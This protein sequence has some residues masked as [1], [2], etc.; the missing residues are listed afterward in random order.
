MNWSSMFFNFFRRIHW[1]SNNWSIKKLSNVLI[2]SISFLLKRTKTMSLPIAVKIDISPLCNLRCT[3]CVHCH[4]D[5]NKILEKQRFNYKQQMSVKQYERIITEIK[6]YVSV[7]SLY[8]FGD[9]LLHPDL[10]KLCEVTANAGLNSHV[11]TN[12]SLNMSDEKIANLIKSGLTFL[13]VCVDGISQEKYSKTRV[14]G[15]VELVLL[16]LERFCKIRKQLKQTYPKIEVQYIKYQHNIDEF[17]EAKKLLYK[18]GVDR[19]VEFWGFLHNY[20]DN[21]P[22]NIN[23]VGPQKQR[24]F[25]RCYW[26]YFFMLIKY[27]GDVL[28]CCYYRVGEQYSKT[29]S[30]RVLGNVFDTSIREVWNSRKYQD[31]RKLVNDPCFVKNDKTLED[32]FCYGCSSLFRTDINEVFSVFKNRRFEDMYDTTRKDYPVR[33]MD[34]V[35]EKSRSSILD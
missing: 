34:F 29:N 7:V 9:P 27:N 17:E 6:N 2:A 19:V 8:Y 23:V 31:S 24:F 18:C 21:D 4:P 12:L 22:S 35:P 25:P 15:N 11:C 30:P 14:G 13:T 3:V 32:N 28:P 1:W 33:K 26:P 10:D 16:N 5:G 20:T